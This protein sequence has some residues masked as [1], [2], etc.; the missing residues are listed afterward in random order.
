M[1][2][3]PNVISVKLKGDHDNIINTDKIL[4]VSGNEI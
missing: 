2:F 4:G 3:K 1:K